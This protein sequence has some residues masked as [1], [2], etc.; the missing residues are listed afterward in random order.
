[1]INKNLKLE[2]KAKGHKNVKSTHKSTLEITKEDYLTPTGD[3]I[4]AINSNIAINDLPEEF[5][6]QLKQGKSLKITLECKDSKTN[7]IYKDTI[8]SKGS[9]DLILNHNTDMVIRKSTHICPR[10]LSINADKS[11]K[12]LNR[13]LIDCLK[14]ESE[15]LIEFEI[16]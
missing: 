14:Q 13:D 7:E 4:V 16:I 15:L 3:C 12:D 2:F 10:T 11:A 1:M 6:E 5:K 9:K 8:I